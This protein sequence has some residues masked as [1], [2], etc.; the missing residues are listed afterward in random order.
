MGL[1]ATKKF[2][3][4]LQS[5]SVPGGRSMPNTALRVLVFVIGL[6]LPSFGQ[7]FGEITG[8]VTDS[9]GAIVADVAITVTNPQT[10]FTRSAATN[11]TGSYTFPALLP[12]VYNLRAEMRGFQTEVRSGVELQVQQ[13]ARID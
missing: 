7:T 10:N 4:L 1:L 6:T 9:S 13:V 8:V 11:S 12:G 3:S 2:I 5:S